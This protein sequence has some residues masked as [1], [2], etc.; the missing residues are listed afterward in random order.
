MA[1]IN[2]Y[3]LSGL[4]VNDKLLASDGDTGATKNVSPE[5]VAD[6]NGGAI[7]YRAFLTQ[8]G[9]NAPV[10]VVAGP[11]TIGNIVWTRGTTGTYLGTLAN[12]FQGNVAVVFGAVPLA[13]DTVT[14]AYA[15]TS[16]IITLLTYDSGVL[17]DASLTNQYVEIRVY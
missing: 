7:I 9:T 8:T 10:A 16:G 12:A 15:N 17:S 2:N 4:K 13:N 3:A 5:D 1:N 11:N 14:F 6:L